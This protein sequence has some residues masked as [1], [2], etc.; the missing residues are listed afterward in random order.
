MKFI[1]AFWG[2]LDYDNNGLRKEIKE[3]SINER[4]SRFGKLDMVV[5]VWGTKNEE[6]I[7]SLGKISS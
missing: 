6:Y 5:Y 3:T 1:R 7:K 4:L 2:D